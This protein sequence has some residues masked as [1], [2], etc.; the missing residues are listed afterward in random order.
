[1]KQI[2]ILTYILIDTYIHCSL[3]VRKYRKIASRRAVGV[4][5]PPIYIAHDSACCNVENP[6][7]GALQRSAIVVEGVTPRR[8]VVRKSITGQLIITPI[9]ISPMCASINTF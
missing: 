7:H 8:R 5:T 3:F 6:V 4:F 2:F 1:M 9:I